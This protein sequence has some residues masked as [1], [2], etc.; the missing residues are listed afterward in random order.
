MTA[1]DHNGHATVHGIQSSTPQ[2]QR[3]HRPTRTGEVQRSTGE[4]TSEPLKKQVCKLLGYPYPAHIPRDVFVE[5]LVGISTD[6]IHR[7]KNRSKPTAAIAPGVLLNLAGTA[8]CTARPA[9]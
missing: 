6:E 8:S 3:S 1:V 5:Q 2:G 4:Y 9:H 7:A